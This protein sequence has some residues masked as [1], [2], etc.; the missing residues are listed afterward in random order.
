MSRVGTRGGAWQSCAGSSSSQHSD[1]IKLETTPKGPIFANEVT[2]VTEVTNRH[3][4]LL[5]LMMFLD[6][7]WSKVDIRCRVKPYGLT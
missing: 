7:N 4:L 1:N 3:E 2:E 6:F 5:T